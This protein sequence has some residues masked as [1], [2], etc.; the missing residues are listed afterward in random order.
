M[1]IAAPAP[2]HAAL[3]RLALDHGKDVFVEKPLA[4][5]LAEAEALAFDVARSDRVFMVGHLLRHH[6]GVPG[7]GGDRGARRDRRLCATS[8][9]R[10]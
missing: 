6:T 5:D 2:A 10:G 7:P 3:C 8:P 1:I 4:S 9:P